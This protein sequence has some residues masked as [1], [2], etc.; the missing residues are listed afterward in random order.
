MN[1]LRREPNDAPLAI[2]LPPRCFEVD[3]DAATL[4]PLTTAG[5][6]KAAVVVVGVVVVV[7]G[8]ATDVGVVVVV[9]VIVELVEDNAV[10]DLD[11]LSSSPMILI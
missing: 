11:A 6:H 9:V 7:L 4:V 5:V 8:D 2:K 1:A 3:V 10:D